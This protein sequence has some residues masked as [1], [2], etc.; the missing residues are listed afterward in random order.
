MAM[1]FE[2]VGPLMTAVSIEKREARMHFAFGNPLMI[3]GQT[4]KPIPSTPKQVQTGSIHNVCP[5]R[6]V[7]VKF[8]STN[9]GILSPPVFLAENV[10]SNFTCSDVSV[11]SGLA[12]QCQL[13]EKKTPVQIKYTY[14]RRKGLKPSLERGPGFDGWLAVW[15]GFFRGLGGMLSL[16][17][18]AQVSKHT[19]IKYTLPLAG[20]QLEW[21]FLCLKGG[22][23]LS[24]FNNDCQVV[25]GVEMRLR[26]PRGIYTPPPL[27]APTN[28]T[29]TNVSVCSL[30]RG[31]RPAPQ[32][33][34]WLPTAAAVDIGDG[35]P[36]ANM[37]KSPPKARRRCPTPSA[38]SLWCGWLPRLL[39]CASAATTA[40][41]VHCVYTSEH[42][43]EAGPH[44]HRLVVSRWRCG[45]RC[46]QSPGSWQSRELPAQ[47]DY[48]RASPGFFRVLE[49]PSTHHHRH[50][51]DRSICADRGG[52]PNQPSSLVSPC[53]VP[54]S[55]R[56]TLFQS[57]RF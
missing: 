49:H 15:E 13:E 12:L 28:K 53:G 33:A 48:G 51:T 42:E 29:D 36:F 11:T 19:L 50:Q 37:N 17:S 6:E 1:A 27:T 18:G 39:L 25:V 5:H 9:D 38:V 40:P 31:V 43:G 52:S 24:G 46:M 34:V 14:S 21:F 20:L 47:P 10:H 8:M 54:A 35:L 3:E 7:G 41:L 44:H 55:L 23:L 57:I 26:P 16:A 30:R 32:P 22:R 2:A 4:V 56:F 45:D